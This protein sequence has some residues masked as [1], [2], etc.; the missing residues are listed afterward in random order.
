M[1]IQDLIGMAEESNFSLGGEVGET[2]EGVWAIGS[3]R[4]PF[5]LS[6]FLGGTY[7]F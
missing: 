3:L 7:L 5:P 4:I 1:S 6:F 2:L